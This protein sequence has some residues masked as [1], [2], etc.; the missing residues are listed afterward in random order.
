MCSQLKGTLDEL[1]SLTDVKS[2]EHCVEIFKIRGLSDCAL[3][4]ACQPD[5][6]LYSSWSVRKVSMVL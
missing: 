3:G 1:V 2:L 4:F 6:A 5:A